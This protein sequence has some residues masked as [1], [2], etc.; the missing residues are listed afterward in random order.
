[1]KLKSVQ[2]ARAQRYPIQGLIISYLILKFQSRKKKKENKMQNHDHVVGAV[3][4]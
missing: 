4:R 2:L 1:M 3:A